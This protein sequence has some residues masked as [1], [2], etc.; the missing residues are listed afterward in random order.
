MSKLEFPGLISWIDEVGM[1]ELHKK[2]NNYLE[3]LGDMSDE[4]DS[5]DLFVQHEY[6]IMKDQWDIDLNFKRDI[7]VYLETNDVEIDVESAKLVLKKI[8]EDH[9]DDIRYIIENEELAPDYNSSLAIVEAFW[10]KIIPAVE[11]AMNN[12]E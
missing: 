10:D 12:L 11:N 1:D 7:N 2:Y 5:F 9:V 3:T 6:S 8:L 4:E